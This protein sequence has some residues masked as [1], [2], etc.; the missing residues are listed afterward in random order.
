MGDTV[1]LHEYETTLIVR[2][3]VDDAAVTEILER[4]E[5]RLVE[6]KATLLLRDDWGTRKL[7]YP[8]DGQVK[9]RY[10]LFSYLSEAESIA[11]F[12]RRVR[13]E[14]RIIRFLTIRVSN[15]VDV[16]TR[17]AEAKETREKRAEEAARRAAEVERQASLDQMDRER[18]PEPTPTP[19]Q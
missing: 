11:E 3:D 9:G 8:I 4:F 6:G 13:I 12:E 10:V 15:S 7:A 18:A 5:G 19:A 16:P 17:L 14:D 1:L 2:S